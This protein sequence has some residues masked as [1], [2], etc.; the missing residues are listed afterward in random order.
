M[1]KNKNLQIIADISNANGAP[2]F[3]DEVVKQIKKH[4]EGLG[5]LK[6]DSLRNVYI[7]RNENK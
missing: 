5:E 1:D 6:E 4:A 2:G 3:E 7:K